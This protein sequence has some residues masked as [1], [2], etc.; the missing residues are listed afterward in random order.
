MQIIAIFG[1]NSKNRGNGFDLSSNVQMWT[2]WFGLCQK[3]NLRLMLGG[4]LTGCGALAARYSILLFLKSRDKGLA[5]ASPSSRLSRKTRFKAKLELEARFLR[6]CAS[7][8]FIFHAHLAT[9]PQKKKNQKLCR[10]V[11]FPVEVQ[12]DL[13][14]QPVVVR[15]LE[16]MHYYYATVQYIYVYAP[17]TRMYALYAYWRSC[18][19][20]L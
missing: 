9:Q 17:H 13:G 18:M 14:N 20:P 2:R 4:L 16:R 15:D 10:L 12:A 3:H 8:Q 7:I 11:F 1:K 6:A 19:M 5:R